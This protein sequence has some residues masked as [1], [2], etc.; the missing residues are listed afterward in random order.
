MIL[1]DTSVLIAIRSVILPA[2][3]IALSAVSYGELRF[4]IERARTPEER[5][6]RTARLAQ[7]EDMF[8]ARWL[9]YDERAAESNG[10]LA[11]IVAR[12]RSKHARTKD[13]M[14]AAHAHALGA[15]FV[16]LNPKDFEPLADEIEIIVPELR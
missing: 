1:V 9:P 6:T 15:S 7:L 11:A 13:V 8:P 2:A 10:R 3:S 14:L 5:R 12:T 4:G 16:T